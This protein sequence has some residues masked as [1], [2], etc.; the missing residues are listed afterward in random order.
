MDASN[1]NGGEPPISNTTTYIASIIS[2]Y[3]C[4]DARFFLEMILEL[5]KQGRMLEAGI[6]NKQ[7]DSN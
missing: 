7:D 2:T 4:N 5:A 3:C 1:G 6:R